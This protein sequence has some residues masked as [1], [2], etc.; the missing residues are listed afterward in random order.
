MAHC[1]SCDDE[2]AYVEWRGERWCSDCFKTEA[3][4]R[5]CR[6]GWINRVVGTVSSKRFEPPVDAADVDYES[7][8]EMLVEYTIFDREE[9]EV[10][11][12]GEHGLSEAE[13]ADRLDIE[14]SVVASTTEQIDDRL[15]RARTTLQILE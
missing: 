14:E 6:E 10:L 5:E 4:S 8:V 12:L 9:A 13:I 11:V 1:H 2:P 3:T 7:R 15:E